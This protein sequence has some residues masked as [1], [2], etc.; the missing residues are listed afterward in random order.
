MIQEPEIWYRCEPFKQAHWDYDYESISY[1]DYKLLWREFEV[2][3][4]PK[5]VQAQERTIIGLE[6]PV[7]VLGNARKQLCLPTRELALQDARVRADYHVS[8]CKARLHRAEQLRKI[9]DAKG[10][11]L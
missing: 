1:Y 4:T 10:D 6:G 9:L 3:H 8:G 11:L 7:F 2:T 5:G